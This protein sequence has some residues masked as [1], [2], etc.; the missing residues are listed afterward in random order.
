VTTVVS[1][2]PGA[3]TVLAELSSART[4]WL[5][6]APAGPAGRSLLTAAPRDVTVID[7]T[8]PQAVPVT[9][10]PFEPA[11]GYPV[12]AHADR[13]GGLFEAAFGLSDPVAGALRAGL[14]R[15]YADGGWDMLTGAARPG[16]VSPPAVPAF[17]QLKLATVDAARDLGY[18]PGM[19]AG[20][21]GFL[22]ARLDA[23]WTGPAGHFLEGGHPAA[24]ARLLRGNVLV[25]GSGLA[26][27]QASWF[28]AGV[29]LL[30]L[31]GQLSRPA[32]RPSTP[33][34]PA[35]RP[36]DRGQPSGPRPVIVIA[37]PG[38]S[39]VSVGPPVP[40]SAATSGS[41]VPGD[42]AGPGQP[43]F[44]AVPGLSVRG[45]AWF[46]RL[47]EDLRWAG[48][49]IVVAP[50]GEGDRSAPGHPRTPRTG[51]AASGEAPSGEAPSGTAS[52]GGAPAVA[53][54]LAGRR[55]A[56]CGE[57]CRRRPCSGYEVHVAGLLAGDP[58]QAW[59]RLWARALVLAFLAGRPVPG[60]PAPLRAGGQ[61]LSPRGRECLLAT[62]IEVA[63]GARA[64]ALRP[65]YDPRCLTAV[66]AAV[67]GRMLADG[68]AVPVR[69]GS[70]WVIPQLR[71]LHEMERLSPLG[72]DRLRP[73]DI[74]P[75]LDFGLAGLPDWPGI[76]VADRLRG[77][78]GHPLA[79]ESERNRTAALTA[80]LGDGRADLDADLAIA[81]MGISP[82][83]R[84][85]HAA[86]AM[87]AA[88]HGGQ[89]GW[90][91]VVLSWPHRLIGEAAPDPGHLPDRDRIASGPR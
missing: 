43:A 38:G 76:R 55:S 85:R 7:V 39:P 27:E 89:P 24:L 22:E 82:P 53:A 56:A 75:P 23:L 31:A 77:L 36:D 49:D 15:A 90:L 58:G 62:V 61:A 30:R 88:G 5:A 11:P 6:L 83:R 44:P 91:E 42:P 48:A 10:N 81:G 16:A 9:V 59:L 86:R 33:A 35:A 26:D 3:A 70:V 45:T 20:V 21:R 17:R 54:L 71:W 50:A 60:V 68:D 74:A 46:G 87:G 66:V 1:T 84:L 40:G 57:R 73:D 18:G 63:V 78:R 28:L 72:R 79:M 34:G 80:L 4:P 32:A 12:Q 67:A 2:V 64:H 37:V 19:L 47:L 13:L 51:E 25:T 69:A 65:C 8:D 52:S 14:R 29:L 41:R